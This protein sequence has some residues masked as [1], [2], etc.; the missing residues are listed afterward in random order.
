MS[1][2]APGTSRLL[3][4]ALWHQFNAI[5]RA[6]RTWMHGSANDCSWHACPGRLR[7]NERSKAGGDPTSSGHG[8]NGFVRSSPCGG[9]SG[10]ATRVG[11]RGNVVESECDAVALGRTDLLPPLSSGGALVARPWLRFHIPL[12]EPGLVDL[13]H[14]ALGQDLT[15]SPT[16][17]RAQAGTGV[18]ARSA[19][20]GAGVDMSRPCVA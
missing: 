2:L 7:S 17:R 11:G 4:R 15:L 18:R 8:G 19:R 20:K 5:S 1:L 14:P 3:R 13:P 12:I 6:S 16:A 10:V 9:S